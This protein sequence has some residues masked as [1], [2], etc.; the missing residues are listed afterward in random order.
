MTWNSSLIHLPNFFSISPAA[1]PSWMHYS[2]LTPA[3]IT[4]PFQPWAEHVI[5]LY[6]HLHHYDPNQLYPPLLV[7]VTAAM[8]TVSNMSRPCLN[9]ELIPLTVAWIVDDLSQC[10]F[11]NINNRII[12]LCTSYIPICT[13]VAITSYMHGHVYWISH[14]QPL[15][16]IILNQL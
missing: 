9:N 4:C 1:S 12:V 8:L 10:I 5:T 13:Y 2:Y 16:Q 11:V 7:I 14:I 15:I 6:D 3:W